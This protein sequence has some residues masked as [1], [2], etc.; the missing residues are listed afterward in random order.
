MNKLLFALIISF[1]FI[2]PNESSAWTGPELKECFFNVGWP[3]SRYIARP[4]SDYENSNDGFDGR[5]NAK[6]Q[7]ELLLSNNSSYENLSLDD[8]FLKQDT[9]VLDL[10]AEIYLDIYDGISAYGTQTEVRKEFVL[11][12]LKESLDF[13]KNSGHIENFQDDTDLNKLIVIL[14]RSQEK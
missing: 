14:L 3:C 11:S 4:G 1:T 12:E 13:W 9:K 5:E 6:N 8:A 10:Y 2:T 7:I